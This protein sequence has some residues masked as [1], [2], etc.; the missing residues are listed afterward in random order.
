M[1]FLS[2]GLALALVACGN[3]D[4]STG[5]EGNS[6]EK[7]EEPKENAEEKPKDDGSKTVDASKQSTEAAGMK[8]ALGEVKVAADKISVGINLENTTSDALSFFPDQGHVVIGDMQLDANLL[9]TTGDIGGEV[10][11]GVKQDGVIEFLAPDSKQIDVASVKEIKFLFGDV[12]TAD[13]TQ[14]KP[15]EFTVPVE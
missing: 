3:S 8:V 15:V 11:G 6:T 14:T 10:Q 7:K 5:S 4:V 9:M 1:L 2:L 13:F 12:M